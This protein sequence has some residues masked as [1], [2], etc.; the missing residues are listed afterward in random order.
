ME[1]VDIRL[2]ISDSGLTYKAIAKEIGIHRGSLSRLMRKDLSPENR[3]RILT[4]INKIK[5][6]E[7]TSCDI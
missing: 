7:G 3:T 6:R 5:D 2:L 4:A 1:N